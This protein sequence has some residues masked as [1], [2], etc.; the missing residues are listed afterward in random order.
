[1]LLAAYVL[2]VLFLVIIE[3]KLVYLATPASQSWSQPA[4]LPAEDVWLTAADGTAIHAWWVPRNGA[5][6]AIL[7]CHGQQGN[8]SH[9]GAVLQRLQRLGLS[10][11]IFDYPGFG[12]SEGSPTEQGCYDAA[13]A[14]YDW[15]IE[16]KRIPPEEIVVLGK[17]LGGGIATDLASRR[18]CRAL[19]LVMSFTSIPDVGQHLLPLVPA[20][21]LMR[22][23][24]DNLAKIEKCRCPVYLA[25]GADDWKIPASHSEKLRDAVKGRCRYHCMPGVGH[26]WPCLTDDCLDD[27]AAFLREPRN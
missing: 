1:M 14:A 22:N 15:L 6:G 9:R 17:S 16:Q 24:F 23:R 5:R 2:C 13:D 10:M 18:D 26:G 3:N 21:L 27:L 4:D 11:L 19:V 7:F 20:K 12:R 8:L 25:H